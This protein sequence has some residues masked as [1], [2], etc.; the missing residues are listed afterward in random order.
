M[1]LNVT[2]KN[3]SMKETG[4]PRE[5]YR[6]KYRILHFVTIYFFLLLLKRESSKKFSNNS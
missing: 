6:Q 3:I 1:V 2:F 4:V 5:I